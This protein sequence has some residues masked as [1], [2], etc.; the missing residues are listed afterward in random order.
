MSSFVFTRQRKSARLVVYTMGLLCLIDH[1][2]LRTIVPQILVNLLQTL[3]PWVLD[4]RPAITDKEMLKASDE[5]EG[6]EARAT[7]EDFKL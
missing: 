5:E 2:P 1:L 7:T 6:P 3:S 4:F